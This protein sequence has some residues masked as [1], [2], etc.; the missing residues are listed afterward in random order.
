MP[1]D[2]A[3]G[4]VSQDTL[5]RLL[6]RRGIKPVEWSTLAEHKEA[7]LQRF[8]PTFWFRHQ[9]LLGFALIASVG[10]MALSAGAANAAMPPSSPLALWISMGWL[11]LLAALILSGVFRARGGSHWEERCLPVDRLDA[12]GVPERIAG[13]ARS[14]QCEAPGSS[15]ILGELIRESVVLD[16]YLLLVQGEE[17]ICLGVWDDSGIIASTL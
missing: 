11:T 15:L 13:V 2:A 17:Q 1:F 8:G 9:K 10:C 12:A 7:Q 3:S 16:P 5:S 14:L 6:E 4:F